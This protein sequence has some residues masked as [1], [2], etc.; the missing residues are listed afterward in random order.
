MLN[1]LLSVVTTKVK[2]ETVGMK[3]A[4]NIADIAKSLLPGKALKRHAPIS[5]LAHTSSD[6]E[7]K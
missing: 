6:S 2:Q 5:A 1:L 4:M 7:K 3:K